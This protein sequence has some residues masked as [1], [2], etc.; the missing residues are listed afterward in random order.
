V[1]RPLSEQGQDGGANITAAAAA[2]AVEP[3]L[4]AS[5]SA[6]AEAET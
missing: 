3:A 4:A 1:H 6:W 5:V 2:G